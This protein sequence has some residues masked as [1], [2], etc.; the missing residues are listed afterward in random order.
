MMGAL[1]TDDWS[2]CYDK[3][4]DQTHNSNTATNESSWALPL[5][6]NLILPENADHV[7][8]EFADLPLSEG[9][10]QALML[11]A[12]IAHEFLALK[13]QREAQLAHKRKKLKEEHAQQVEHECYRMPL[14]R[15]MCDQR[16]PEDSP[17]L[18]LVC[19]DCAHIP[20]GSQDCHMS[21][22]MTLLQNEVSALKAQS[23]ELELWGDAES[24]ELWHSHRD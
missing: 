4:S 19:Y 3:M 7:I 16:P 17:C 6:Q 11:P 21:P 23:R 24:N 22:Q 9:E 5:D 1:L 13:S 20:I 12:S 8:A 15:A 14:C 2:A 18:V 10:D